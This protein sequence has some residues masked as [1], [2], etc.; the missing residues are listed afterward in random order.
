MLIDTHAHLFLEEFEEDL[1]EVIDRARDAGVSA[2]YMPNID[3]TTVD[4]MLSVCDAYPGYCFPMIGLHPT[5]VN[6]HY[7]QELAILRHRLETSRRF[8]AI[9]EIGL[10]LYWDTTFLSEQLSAFEKQIEWA[11]AFRLPVVIHIREALDEVCRVMEKFKTTPLRGVFHSFTGSVE[12]ARQLL[13]FENF[14]LGINGIVTFKKATLSETLTEIPLERIILET[15]APYL[16]PTP[17]RGRRNESAFIK[18]TLMKVAEVY[19]MTPEEVAQA[20][21]ENARKL[22]CDG[23]LA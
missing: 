4:K 9:G 3:G 7:E 14:L 2:I 11:L 8:I 16:S 21:S 5:S 19:R 22:F 15:D 10:D 23:F 13:E 18:N 1:P 17:H 12:E 6:E 20:T